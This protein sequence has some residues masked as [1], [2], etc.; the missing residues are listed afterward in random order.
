MKIE[1]KYLVVLCIFLLGNMAQAQNVT[2]KGRVSDENNDPIIGA[3]V[4]VEKTHK[5]AMTGVNGEYQISVQRGD[6]IKFTFV[7]YKTV[8]Y[9]APQRNTT[10]NVTLK[11]DITQIGDVVVIGYGKIRKKDLTGSIE[12]LSGGEITKAMTVNPAEALNG[13]VS[14]VLVT[15][16]SNRPGADM[17][18]QIRGLN[19]FNYSNEPLYVIDGVPSL[20]GM[21]HINPEDIESVDVLKDASS[22]AIYG[23]RGANGVVIITTKGATKKEGFNIEYNGYIGIKTPTRMP[24]MLGNKG[25]GMEYVDFRIK[26]WETKFGASSLSTSAFLTDDERRHIKYGEYYDWLREFAKD[27]VTTNHSLSASGSSE[28]TSYTF[29]IGYMDDGGMAGSENFKRMTANIGIEYHVKDKVRMGVNSYFSHDLINHG[30]YDALFNAYLLSPIVGR[31]LK[32]G[33]ENFEHRPG[34]RV[35]PF[36]QDRNTKNESDGWSINMAAFLAYSPIKELTLKSQIAAQFD[37]AVNGYWTGT[38][39]QYGQGVN[40]PYASRS[41]GNNQNIVWDNTVTY[42]KTFN[43]VH[44]LNVIGLFSMQ[45][46]THKG[47]GMTGEGL[48]YDSDWHAIQTADQI[49][50]V[51]S[52][53]WE[54]MMMSFMGRANYVYDDRYLL[55]LTARYDG[56]SRLAKKNRWGLLPSAAIGWSLKNE[57]FLKDVKWLEAL[58]LR[59]SWGKSGNDNV[60]YNVTVTKLGLNPYSLGGSGVKGFGLGGSLGNENLKW[61]MTSEWNFGLD[62]GLFQNRISGNLDVYFRR[63]TDLIFQKQVAQV[64]GY[65]SILQNIGTTQNRG[66]E[67]TINSVNLSNKDFSWKTN[68]TFSLNRNKIID[69]DGTKTDDLANRRFIGHPMNVYYDVK[70]IGIWQEDEKDEASKYSAAPGWPKIED[71]TPDGKIDANDY[72][73]LGTQSPDWTAGMTNTFTYKNFDMSIYM[74]AQIGG[75]Y[76]DSFTYWFLGMNN[77]DWNKLKVPYWTPENRNN[78]YPG[79]GLDCLWT[80]GLAQVKGTFLKIQNITLGYTLP[81]KL[82]HRISLKNLRTY[83]SVQNPFT[84]CSYLGSDPQIIGESL[85]QQLSL[86]PMTFTLGLNLKF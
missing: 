21:R 53:Y 79:I 3:S 57:A 30:S 9:V 54:S 71:Y 27:A 75:L 35:N 42:D 44:K 13:R 37:G 24:E 73:I 16:A 74:Y 45:K 25:N 6:V 23:S 56:T 15:K 76:S 1:L 77:Q 43:E 39:S 17:S 84:F 85:S 2:V 50:G 8:T 41:E 65:S 29:G 18:I 22:C 12:S 81:E 28:K 7:G 14:G 63:T 52:Y 34:G 46:D 86:Y 82:L 20:S 59:A 61:E 58:K 72:H 36:I 19:S 49:T 60:D 38:Y 78:K 10:L 69:L 80:Q 5:G 68:F 55:T 70:Q 4:F 62:F 51:S 67:V 33:S 64:N 83:I 40:K 11:E 26:Q 31:Y 32:D 47:S 66:F 48:P